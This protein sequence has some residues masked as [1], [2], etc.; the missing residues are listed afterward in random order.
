LVRALYGQSRAAG[1]VQDTVVHAEFAARAFLAA[2]EIAN[3]TSAE[4]I[5][6]MAERVALGSP[7][8]AALVRERQDNSRRWATLRQQ[9]LQAKLRPSAAR[10]FASEDKVDTTL[11]NLV[12]RNTEI[13][14]LVGR[15]F[16]RFASLSR[17]QSVTIGDVRALLRDREALVLT[18]AVVPEIDG[19]TDDTFVWVVTKEHVQWTRAKMGARKLNEAVAAL[20]CGLDMGAWATPNNAAKCVERLGLATNATPP[21][22]LPFDT[23][24]AHQLYDTLLGESS[25]LLAGKDLIIVPTGPLASLPLEVLV[26]TPS[27]GGSAYADADWLGRRNALTVLPSVDSLRLLRENAKPSRAPKAFIGLADPVLEGTADCP[28]VVVPNQ[29]PDQATTVAMA[30]P[31]RSSGV[32]LRPGNFSRA[33]QADLAAV[34]AL[35]PLPDTAYEVRCVARSLDADPEDLLIGKDLTETKLKSLPLDRY[36]ILHF[37][38]HGLLSG[39]VASTQA[40]REAEPALV[41]TPPTAAN[42]D[43]DGLLT[44]SEIAA[45]K[46]D[47]DWVIMSA[48]NT[49]AG[50]RPGAEPLS[51][52]AKAF[53][54]AGARSLLVSHWPVDSYAA[55]M[56]TTRI[57]A[58]LRRDPAIGRPEAVRRAIVALMTDTSRPWAAHPAIWAP[59]VLVGEGG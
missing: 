59:F 2:Q 22:P 39:E 36:R 57:F 41:L 52:L 13:D 46:L 6:Q 31:G 47:A 18:L 37:A 3:S 24:R 38:T 35:C 1:I 33:R 4:A 16:T 27:A 45:L 50:D 51:G 9:L 25:D 55:T 54:Y 32:E 23:A 28:Q 21:S 5:G 11:A 40:G 56:I 20:R 7:Q 34:R 49:A 26:V 44:A 15:D 53:F 58:E 42:G 43:D 29:C 12:A 17:A 30:G 10:D 19:V 48:C 8:L 14:A